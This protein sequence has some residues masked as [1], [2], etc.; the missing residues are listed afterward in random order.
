MTQMFLDCFET[1][2]SCSLDSQ[3][4]QSFTKY[5]A[6]GFGGA[7]LMAPGNRTPPLDCDKKFSLTDLINTF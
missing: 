3:K 2:Y 6:S 5:F 4:N 7:W 1:S